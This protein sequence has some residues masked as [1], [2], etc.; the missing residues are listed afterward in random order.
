[1]RL[2]PLGKV[3]WAEEGRRR[4]ALCHELYQALMLEFEADHD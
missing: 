4:E 3:S 2:V 1:M